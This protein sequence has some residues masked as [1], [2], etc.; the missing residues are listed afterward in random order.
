[1]IVDARRGSIPAAEI[2]RQLGIEVLQGHAVIAAAGDRSVREVTVAP[3]D[4]AGTGLAGAASTLT[5]DLLCV[6][7]GWSPTVHLFSQSGGKLAFDVERAC[8]VPG[9]SVQRERSAGAARGSLTLAECLAAGH[10][11]GL[12]AARAAGFPLAAP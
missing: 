7:G 11:A 9:P 6:S 4:G 3:L 5:C 1:G 2:C 10:A 12:E 8:F